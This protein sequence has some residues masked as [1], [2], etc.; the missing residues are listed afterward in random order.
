MQN[1]TIPHGTGSDAEHAMSI[2]CGTLSHIIH[3]G[4]Y[5]SLT[6]NW[7]V[8]RDCPMNQ[9]FLRSHRRLSFGQLSNTKRKRPK[10]IGLIK[11]NILLRSLSSFVVVLAHITYFLCHRVM[12]GNKV[13]HH[14][15]VKVDKS[16][17]YTTPRITRRML[18]T[19]WSETPITPMVRSISINV[20]RD[21]PWPDPSIGLR[22]VTL[23]MSPALNWD[24]LCLKSSFVR[25]PSLFSASIT[26]H[27]FKPAL[28]LVAPGISSTM[29][30]PCGPSTT[31]QPI[32]TCS[33]L[34]SSFALRT[35][36]DT[37][38]WDDTSVLA[39]SE[40]FLC[41]FFSFLVRNWFQLSHGMCQLDHSELETCCESTILRSCLM[42]ALSSS[43]APSCTVT[44]TR[45]DT[46]GLWNTS[47][48]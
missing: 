47:S 14:I 35:H 34:S 10:T 8:A 48:T 6:I 12:S 44:W 3:F 25:T 29:C 19:C 11:S 2:G 5:P 15:L 27:F 39:P 32:A 24:N 46:P 28:S 17:S 42:Y 13:C 43:F 30:T 16:D 26:S 9:Q 21:S 18:M 1:Y 36:R 45:S 33:R 37:T 40:V 23:Q 41:F 22:I 4:K 20:S 38:F 7:T 31:P